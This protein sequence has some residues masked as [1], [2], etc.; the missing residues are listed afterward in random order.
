MM[1]LKHH[2]FGLLLA[3]IIGGFCGLVFYDWFLKR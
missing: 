2:V 3:L 1:S